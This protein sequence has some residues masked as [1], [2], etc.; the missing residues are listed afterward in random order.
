LKISF[1][2]LEVKYEQ[3]VENEERLLQQMDLMQKEMNGL[4]QQIS[5]NQL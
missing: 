1:E 4:G 2:K 3:M 5:Q